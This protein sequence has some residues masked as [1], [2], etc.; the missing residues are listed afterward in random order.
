M[1]GH[2]RPVRHPGGAC[3]LQHAAC[4]ALPSR[5]AEH[6][7]CRPVASRQP[8]RHGG[9]VGLAVHRMAR[10]AR[11]P[12]GRRGPGVHAVRHILH[13]G[14][15]AGGW[16]GRDD[17]RS[18]DLPGAALRLRPGA[19]R[20]IDPSA[21][22]DHGGRPAGSGQARRQHGGRRQ[23]RRHIAQAGPGGTDGDC[24]ERPAAGRRRCLRGSTNS[25]QSSPPGCRRT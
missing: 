2:L 17:A 21:G 13:A 11:K 22:G 4:D 15:D 18:R 24:P 20:R 16:T 10:A 5:G 3:L 25:W 9:Y 6:G 7:E 1:A 23:S 12:A 19:G 8:A 14:P